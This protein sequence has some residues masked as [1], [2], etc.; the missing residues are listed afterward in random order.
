[1][2]SL[3][4]V[5]GLDGDVGGQHEHLRRDATD[6]QAGAAE[7]ATLDDRDRPIGEELGDRIARPAPDDDQVEL[8]EITGIAARS[9]RTPS[10]E[11]SFPLPPA[12]VACGAHQPAEGPPAGRPESAFRLFAT[13]VCATTSRRVFPGDATCAGI[14][15][16]RDTQLRRAHL[17]VPDERARLRTDRRSARGRRDGA[18]RLGGRRRRR[19][20]QHVLHP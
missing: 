3:V 13:G 6:V 17:R 12:S 1:M 4:A 7:R 16:R 9:E 14:L 18:R 11:D 2:P 10:C 19:R 15:D 8:F 5:T 20:A